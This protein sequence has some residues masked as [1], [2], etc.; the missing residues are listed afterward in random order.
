VQKDAGISMENVIKRRFPAVKTWHGRHGRALAGIR[1]LGHERWNK[2]FSFAFV[3]NPWDRLVS[4]YAMIQDAKRRLPFLKRFS[5]RPFESELWN[6]AVRTSRDFESFLENCTAVVFDRDCDKSF[7]YNQIDYLSDEG[8][9]LVVS[10]VGRFENLAADI[11]PVFERIGIANET[12]PRLNKKQTQ[13]LQ[14]LVYSENPGPCGEAI[15][16]GY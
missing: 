10:F 6:Y 11:G 1:E 9:K 2:Y 7:A 13:S 3:R 5:I 4:W 16:Q 14:Q 12:L 15:C 8:G